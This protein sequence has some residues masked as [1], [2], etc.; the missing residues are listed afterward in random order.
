M[1]SSLDERP[2]PR[3]NSYKGPKVLALPEESLP[4]H[5][6]F[7]TEIDQAPEIKTIPEE[8]TIK[9]QFT[10]ELSFVHNQRLIS[11]DV[12]AGLPMNMSC[13]SRERPKYYVK[14]DYKRLLSKLNAK[15]TEDNDCKNI[16]PP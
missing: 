2:E 8:S 4:M 15:S 7:T 3:Y 13:I 14:N 10:T 16:T 9:Q 5:Q 11:E 6:Q 12:K 1:K